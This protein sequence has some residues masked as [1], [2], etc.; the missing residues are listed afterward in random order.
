MF[1]SFLPSTEYDTPKCTTKIIT[2]DEARTLSLD[3][4][5][6]F[7]PPERGDFTNF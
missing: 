7:E 3:Y 2:S 6:T 5:T 1:P 4:M